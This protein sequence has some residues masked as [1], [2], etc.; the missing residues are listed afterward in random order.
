MLGGTKTPNGVF[1]SS[2][3]A[4]SSRAS[5]SDFGRAWQDEQPP[6]AENPF[7]ARRIAAAKRG[8]LGR[9]EPLGRAQKPA[10]APPAA[11]SART[12]TA[13]LSKKTHQAGLVRREAIGLVARAAIGRHRAEWQLSGPRGPAERLRPPRPR[14]S[15]NLSA[16]ALKPAMSSQIFGEALVSPV[17][18]PAGNSASTSNFSALAC[19]AVS[20]VQHLRRV[21]GL[22]ALHHFRKPA[23][24]AAAFLHDRLA[25]RNRF[26]KRGRRDERQT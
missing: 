6:A 1:S 23:D 5:P 14:R 12:A 11:T 13:S 3:P 26:G 24:E 19:S 20:A 10:A 2:P 9:V 22:F 21:K 17:S 16:A 4:S 7:A 25:I 18:V 15:S 8:E